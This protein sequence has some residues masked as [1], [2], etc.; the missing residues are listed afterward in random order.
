MVKYTTKNSIT[1]AL[2]FFFRIANHTTAR[3][4]GSRNF[5]PT[6][7]SVKRACTSGLWFLAAWLRPI[8]ATAIARKAGMKAMALS[9]CPKKLVL[10]VRIN[11]RPERSTD[12]MERIAKSLANRFKAY[13][14]SYQVFY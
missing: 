10:P 3:I 1:S 5:R 9:A 4:A 13:D 6:A 14:L 7:A 2:L 8:D 12:R 11:V